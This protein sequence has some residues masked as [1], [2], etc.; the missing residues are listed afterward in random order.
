MSLSARQA[1]FWCYIGNVNY[2][3]TELNVFVDAG[4]NAHGNYGVIPR[5]NKHEREAQTHTQEGQSPEGDR[6]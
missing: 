2:L 5:A 6:M 4:G 1:C 3:P